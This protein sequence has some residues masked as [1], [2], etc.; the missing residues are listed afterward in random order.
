[1]V[2]K[3]TEQRGRA[4]HTQRRWP[5]IFRNDERQS[6]DLL[7]EAL[8]ARLRSTHFREM[9]TRRY[10]DFERFVFSS[11]YCSKVGRL[12]DLRFENYGDRR[13]MTGFAHGTNADAERFLL[14][15]KPR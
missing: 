4:G 7:I 5:R 3:T 11:V 9:E 1:M 12:S 13:I 2:V 8:T 10:V 14:Q 6:F 15:P